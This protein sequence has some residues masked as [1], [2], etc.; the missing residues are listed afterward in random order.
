MVKRVSNLFPRFLFNGGSPTPGLPKA[1]VYH[2]SR[3]DR[4]V[5]HESIYVWKLMVMVSY[6]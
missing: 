6:W 2:Y 4:G 3:E 1:G 5:K